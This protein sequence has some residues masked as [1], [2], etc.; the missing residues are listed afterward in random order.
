[1]VCI[2]I[3]TAFVYETWRGINDRILHYGDAFY[4]TVTTITTTGFG[5]ISLVG[6]WGRTIS[7]IIMLCGVTL[8]L[9][10]AQAMSR[11]SKVE[12]ECQACGLTRHDFAAVCCKAFG[13]MLKIKDEG[14]GLG[15]LP[16]P[17]FA[18][19]AHSLPLQQQQQNEN[20]HQ[21]S[22]DHDHRHSLHGRRKWLTCKVQKATL[23]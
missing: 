9:R 20:R 13:E 1:M 10:L 21:E 18:S 15:N 6:T 16:R 23:S 19:A 4:F 11:P 2:F 7:I 14:G 12:R 22:R 8:F 17:A 5:D 3:A